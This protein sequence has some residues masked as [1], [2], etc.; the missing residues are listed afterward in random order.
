MGGR[1]AALLVALLLAAPASATAA[2]KPV[3]RGSTY[4]ALGDSV[5]FGYQEPDV[6]PAPDYA[7]ASSFTGFPE[8][9]ASRLH[10][11]LHNA[12]CPGE[13]SGS[14]LNLSSQSYACE[15]VP[16]SGP[17]VA[18]RT[19]FPLHVKYSGTQ[20]AYAMRF[21]RHHRGTRLVTLMIGANDYFLCQQV[22]ADHCASDDEVDA[23]LKTV[24]DNV[25]DI[26]SALR[27][28]AHYRGQLVLVHYY[29]LGYASDDVKALSARLN[30]AL[31][32][33]VK[34]F[35]VARADGF[36]EFEAA[37]ARFGG[38]PCAAGLLTQLG[39]QAGSCGVH[40]SYAGQVVLSQAVERA[41]RT[42]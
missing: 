5:S 13:T 15:T 40:P 20:I 28:K 37:T 34:G 38:S 16:P 36:G 22:T 29:A 3:K 10:L 6:V 19:A 8:Q 32:A 35:H 26:A 27:R 33:G 21:L 4:L 7:H 14:L 42:P 39:G 30:A 2:A 17:T 12:A 25:R 24:T 41:V 18:Y 9:L 31:D 11:K 23:T 1:A